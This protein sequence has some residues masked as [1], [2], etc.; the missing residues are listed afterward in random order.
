VGAPRQLSVDRRRDQAAVEAAGSLLGKSSAP[1]G[2]PE[3]VLRRLEWTVIRRL[4]GRAQGDFRTAFRGAGIDVRDVR[5]YEYGDDVR[6]IDWNV[7]ARLDSPFVREHTE[8]RELTAWL[9]L[10]RSRSMSFGPVDRPKEL[11]LV[12]LATTIARLLTR[13][14][15]R[16]G[17]IVYSSAVDVSLPARGGRNQVLRL[18]RELLRPP[19][20]EALAARPARGHRGRIRR[21]AA[22][23]PKGST[24]NL[25]DLL[26]IASKSIRRRSM[27]V[28][29]SD[30]IS[31]P[32]W[33]R[34]LTLLGLHHEVL[35]IRLV[36]PR[37][38]ELPDIGAIVVEDP[39]TGE[40]LAVDTSDPQ[41]RRRLAEIAAARRESITAAARRA[42]VDLH[43]V[44]TDD[45]LVDALTRLVGRR[46]RRRRR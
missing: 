22:P 36:D 46:K 17:A 37:E 1:A 23:S 29:I 5:D 27:V 19:L 20:V 33:E 31:E 13:S 38:F 7:T 41:F 21:R 43:E 25:T 12:E 3:A 24:T 42:G 18:T 26:T 44:S 32:G 16:V 2:A 8:D 11:V 6:H 34:P 35:A 28:L 45:D 30:F 4:D 14:G 39:E 9:L 10:D 40:H 15:N